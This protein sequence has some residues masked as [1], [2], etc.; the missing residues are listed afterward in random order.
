[1][2]SPFENR[3]DWQTD[4]N[5]YNNYITSMR[6]KMLKGDNSSFILNHEW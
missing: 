1:M 2:K 6:Q 3:Y 5:N 4:N